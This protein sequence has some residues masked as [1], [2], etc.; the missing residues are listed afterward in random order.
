[1]FKAK[2]SEIATYKMSLGNISSHFIATDA[3]KT[4][5]HGCVYDFSVYYGVF[6]DFEIHDIHAY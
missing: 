6:S 2:D 4:G 3:Q 1:M 5:L